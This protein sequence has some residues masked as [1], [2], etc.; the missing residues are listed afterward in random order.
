VLHEGDDI[1]AGRQIDKGLLELHELH[2]SPHRHAGPLQVGPERHA[3]RVAIRL[4][5]QVAGLCQ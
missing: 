1:G 3:E 2:G 4:A 5:A